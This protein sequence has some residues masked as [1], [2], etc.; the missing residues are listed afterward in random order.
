L[1]A[2]EAKVKAYGETHLDAFGG[3]NPL[4]F[5]SYWEPARRD[6][7]DIQY[8]KYEWRWMSDDIV[9][10]SRNQ[11]YHKQG[12]IVADLGENFKIP[13]LR[14]V[15]ACFFLNKVATENSLLQHE[16]VQNGGVRTYTNVE[17]TAGG[18]RLAFGSSDPSGVCVDFN[19][20][21]TSQNIGAV[22]L[23]RP[24]FKSRWV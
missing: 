12:K 22:A 11:D 9:S 15:A 21:Y 24:S 20:S 17:D 8:P 14:E 4:Q 18:S 5:R 19:G 1:N 2:L 23:W 6:L 10:G 3:K 16:N 13:S 7:G